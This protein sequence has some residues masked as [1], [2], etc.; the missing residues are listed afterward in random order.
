MLGAA[1][2]AA[3]SALTLYSAGNVI[4]TFGT[5]SGLL[6][7]TAAWTSAGGVTIRSVAYML[8]FLAG[9]AMSAALSVSYH[10]RHQLHW[11][12]VATGA[13]GAPA[14]LGGLLVVVPALL[15]TVSL[16]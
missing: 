8:F 10:R 5:L 11:T 16:R 13:T 12:A 3:T 6:E 9:A 2:W 15:T 14:L 4:I 1:L 7:P